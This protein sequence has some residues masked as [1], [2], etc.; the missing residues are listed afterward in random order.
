MSH[1]QSLS[2]ENPG[3]ASTLGNSERSFPP[4]ETTAQGDPAA[5]TGNMKRDNIIVIPH[6]WL[7]D[8]KLVHF[9]LQKQ[10]RGFLV[11]TH[12]ETKGG[13][14]VLGVRAYPKSAKAPALVAF[15][16]LEATGDLASQFTRKEKALQMQV[17]GMW[18]TPPE[19]Q[20]ITERLR[21]VIP[22]V[23]PLRRSFVTRRRT[24]ILDGERLDASLVYTQQQRRKSAH[25]SKPC[26]A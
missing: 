11:Q 14:L 15:I 3:G 5:R 25:T 16:V 10:S 22:G 7:S 17:Y 24:V 4:G 23:I 1:P 21:N 12:I 18:N 19:Y 6:H 20:Q 9:L 13:R 26:A 2:S 8:L